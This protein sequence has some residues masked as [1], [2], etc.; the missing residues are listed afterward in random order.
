MKKSKYVGLAVVCLLLA[1]LSGSVQA[2][3]QMAT[4][5]QGQVGPGG[6]ATVN[7]LQINQGELGFHYRSQADN[8]FGLSFLGQTFGDF[9]GTLTVSINVTTGGVGTG[10]GKSS[11]LITGGSWTL[12]V[13]RTEVRGGFVGSIY[14]TIA[15]GD[16]IPT[17]NPNK[18]NVSMTFNIVG[19][20]LA[21]QGASGTAT[22]NGTLTL[23]GRGGS[24][25]EGTVVFNP[26]KD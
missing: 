6:I 10:N 14:G 12:P 15:Q 23:D 26:V 24:E 16:I 4:Y 21:Y 1:G 25:L 17:A 18:S 9:P 20:T 8:M 7:A 19:G 22:F 2:Q 11:N 13:Y 5:P 3:R